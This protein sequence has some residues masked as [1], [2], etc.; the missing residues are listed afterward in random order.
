MPDCC[1][2][3]GRCVN[4]ILGS[5]FQ[6]RPSVSST[7]RSKA[8]IPCAEIGGARRAFPVVPRAAEQARR[9]MKGADAPPLSTRGRLLPV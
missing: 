7:Y 4:G 8:M 5:P 6:V 2:S 1:C 9:V 3:G